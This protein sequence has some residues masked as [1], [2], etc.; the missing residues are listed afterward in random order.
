MAIYAVKC[1]ISKSEVRE[2]MYKT[3]DELS[4]IEHSNLLEEDDIKSTLE[5]YDRQY[6]NFTIFRKNI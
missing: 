4:E 6:Y 3:F 2:D 1:N 5:A